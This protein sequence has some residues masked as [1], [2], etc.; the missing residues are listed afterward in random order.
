MPR[1]GELP[2]GEATAAM[3]FVSDGDHGAVLIFGVQLSAVAA[4]AV[5][6]R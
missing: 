5:H 3:A 1:D 2:A 6:P 4:A